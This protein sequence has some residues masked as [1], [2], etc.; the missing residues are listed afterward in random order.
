MRGLAAR[1]EQCA[2]L[3]LRADRRRQRRAG[4]RAHQA[5]IAPHGRPSHHVFAAPTGPGLAAM[6]LQLPLFRVTH[7]THSMWHGDVFWAAEAPPTTH[8]IAADMLRHRM[9]P[10]PTRVERSRDMHR[11][12]IVPTPTHWYRARRDVS[13]RAEGMQM[14][15]DAWNAA[16]VST[17]RP[18]VATLRTPTGQPSADEK[19]PHGADQ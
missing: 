5:R 12:S 6:R 7:L 17:R 4:R 16:S 10:H 13:T 1:R 18:P 3:H 15:S 8:Q 19:A 9:P 2:Q 11:P 14:F